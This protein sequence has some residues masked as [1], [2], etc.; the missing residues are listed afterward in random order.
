MSWG[1]EVRIKMEGCQ[2]SV[3]VSVSDSI[4]GHEATQRIVRLSDFSGRWLAG[5]SNNTLG[6]IVQYLKL[7]D[8]SAQ[9]TITRRI[10]S[11]KSERRHG[12]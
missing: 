4:Y 9:L 12:L 1:Q 2:Q 6:M 10:A 5:A 7:R 8:L 3:A 11:I